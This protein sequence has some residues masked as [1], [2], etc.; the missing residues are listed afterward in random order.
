MNPAALVRAYLQA[1]GEKNFAVVRDM[2]SEDVTFAGPAMEIDGAE[3]YVEALRRLAPV[4]VRYDVRKLFVDG[5]DVCAIYDFVTDTAAGAVRSVEWIRLDG[6][7]LRSVEL[8]FDQ[9]LWGAVREA[10]AQ[11]AT[12]TQ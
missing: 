12:M 1:A 6:D 5:T 9:Q 7:K 4:L 11:R 8:F 10:L 3:A 2:L